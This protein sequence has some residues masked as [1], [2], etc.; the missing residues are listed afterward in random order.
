[1]G[2]INKEGGAVVKAKPAYLTFPEESIDSIAGQGV[3]K[4]PL[5]KY[6]H[7][8][9]EK[10]GT[11]GS[12]EVEALLV[13]NANP[14]YAL[15][16][17]KSVK[18]AIGKIPFVVSFSSFMDE[19]A[20]ASDI[21]L[22]VHTFIER[23]EDVPS[24]AGL[25]KT[26]IGLSKPI[27]KPVYDTKHPGDAVILLGQELGASIGDNF[28][29]DSYEECLESTAQNIW[30]ELSEEGFVLMS[31][32]AS[33]DQVNVD[34]SFLT[35]NPGTARIK[36]DGELILI[37]IDHIRLPGDSPPPSPFAIKTVSDD[38]LKGRDSFIDINPQSAKGFKND[39]YVLVK[40]SVGSAKVRINLNEAIM[41]GVIGMVRGLGHS[42]DGNKYVS[43][44]G[45]NINELIGTIIEA[46][47]GLDA[48]AGIGATI[49]RA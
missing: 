29:W 20:M 47:S 26:V 5:G 2:N 31:E 21:I 42:F 40:T 36:G 32:G 10:A 3:K 22:P 49:S 17:A 16:N 13:Y 39:D 1:V 8:F 33:G 12:P 4:A 43:G 6:I 18:E 25:S 37:P 24:G 38:I 28:E 34:A 44:K 30:D 27:V 23:L 11:G 7:D 48:A 46:G 19:T 9:F 35:A 41:P 15:N 45:V 14:C